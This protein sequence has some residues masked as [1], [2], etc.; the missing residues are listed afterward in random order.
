MCGITGMFDMRGRRSLDRALLQRMNDSQ[1]HRGPDGHGEHH[2]PGIALGHRRLAIIDLATGQQPLYNADGSTVIV[3]NGEIYNYQPLMAELQ[4]LGYQFRTRSDTEVIVHAWEA[5]GEKCVERLRGMFAF[6][7]WDANQETLFLARDRLGVKP[8]FYAVLP[9]GMVVFGSELKSVLMHPGVTRNMDPCAV[10]Q[11]FALGYVA[12]PRTIFTSVSK[13]PPGHYVKLRRGHPV[14]ATTEYWDVRFTL[15]NR[16]EPAR[17]ARG[18][19]PKTQ[20][21]GAPADDLRGSAGSIPFRRRRFERGRCSDG[22][23]RATRPSTPARSHS[24][25][26][27]S[28]KRDSRSRSPIAIRPDIAWSAW[29]A[30]TSISST[31]SPRSTTSRMRTVRP[32]RRIVSAS[33]RAST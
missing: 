20:G 26:P 11:Y 16:I 5:W 17:C 1:R 6:A 24:T 28:T 22:S 15:D 9:D 29:R 12:E 32:S 4:A 31:N 8:L 30:R 7:I 18:A 19:R 2:A 14:P 25:I 21:V 27:S 3:F 33:W 10:E 23:G 13:L